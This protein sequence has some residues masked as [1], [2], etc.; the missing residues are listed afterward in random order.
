MTNEI[1]DE[2]VEEALDVWFAPQG[3]RRD[4]DHACSVYKNGMRDA[5]R[6]AVLAERK[7]GIE[8]CA[9]VADPWTWCGY[10]QDICGP[11]IAA[12]I[13]ALGEK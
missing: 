7:R 13:R 10:G 8:E 9:K 2:V 6:A 12:A 3:W 11:K 1:S 5:I 4:T